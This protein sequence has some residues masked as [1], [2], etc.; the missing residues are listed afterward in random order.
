LPNSMSKW[1]EV[2]GYEGTRKK[3]AD[4]FASQESQ[5][6][7]TCASTRCSSN[8]PKSELDSSRVQSEMSFTGTG[9]STEDATNSLSRHASS[10]T[11]WSSPMK[12]GDTANDMLVR[13]LG[14]VHLP[15]P[16]E[17]FFEQVLGA[18]EGLGVEYSVEQG[19][20]SDVVE[21]QVPCENEDADS[22]SSESLSPSSCGSSDDTSTGSRTS[23]QM[24]GQLC[25]QLKIVAPCAS[26]TN[27]HVTRQKGSVLRFHSFYHDFR[28][29]LGGASGWDEKAGR[30]SRIPEA[31]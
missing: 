9:A 14:W 22:S 23:T 8:S 31:Q 17:R 20:W 27:F 4:K 21:V 25:V 30:Y 18:L 19:E 5:D 10:A 3:A 15:A 1:C 11:Q 29:K 26:N 7:E 2:L 6:S 16:K 24:A 12:D 28:N 13:T